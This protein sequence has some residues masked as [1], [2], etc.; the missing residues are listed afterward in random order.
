M[1]FGSD[2][3][4]YWTIISNQWHPNPSSLVMFSFP[5]SHGTLCVIIYHR[6]K[7]GDVIEYASP[8]LILFTSTSCSDQLHTFLWYISC[9]SSYG[10]LLVIINS[11]PKG[12]YIKEVSQEW[13]YQD[14]TIA[15][16][17]ILID[18]STSPHRTKEIFLPTSSCQVRLV[19]IWS[20][21]Y[22]L[23]FVSLNPISNNLLHIKGLWRDWIPLTPINSVCFYIVFQSNAYISSVYFM[24]FI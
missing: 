12:C 3:W 14:R 5:M 21:C 10:K 7:A 22:L 16:K 13:M 19:N 4:H 9:L 20:F 24:P 8:P 17:W 6:Q 18:K 11:C 15:K 2:Q 1:A 23:P